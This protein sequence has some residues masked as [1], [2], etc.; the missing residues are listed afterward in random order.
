MKPSSVK[1]DS[2]NFSSGD[3]EML[4]SDNNYIIEPVKS[5]S[6]FEPHRWLETFG[7]SLTRN[8]IE[9]KILH[10][11]TGLALALKRYASAPL[12]QTVE[13]SG[14][15]GYKEESTLLQ[16]LLN[17]LYP[18]ISNEVINRIDVAIDFKGKI[19]ERVIKAL[20]KTRG[21]FQWFNTTYF[22]TSKENK[23]NPKLNILMYPKHKKKNSLD[24]ELNRLE[25]SFRGGYFNKM[26]VKDMDKAYKKMQ[27][28]IKRLSGI[29]VEIEMLNTSL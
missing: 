25:F 27:K 3:A 4:F 29:D 28:T 6:V 23:S 16:Q 20:Q 9:A 5:I 13:F 19:P 22:K 21:P 10:T 18:D 12:K 2:F 24:Y 7:K 26:K 14:L 1:I 17:E 11:S 15:S 8:I